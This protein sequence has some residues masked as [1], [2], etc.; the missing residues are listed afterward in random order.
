MTPPAASTLYAYVTSRAM[1]STPPM[2]TD[3]PKVLPSSVV[4]PE[5]LVLSD[6]VRHA[7]V[8]RGLERGD[9]HRVPERVVHAHRPVEVAA[10]VARREDLVAVRV[11]D[12]RV[13]DLRRRAPAQ[14]LE[15]AGVRERLQRRSG[16]V[17]AR[18]RCRSARRC[19]RGSSR[20]SRRTSAPPTCADRSRRARRCARSTESSNSLIQCSSASCALCSRFR[21]S[22]VVTRRPPR[23]SASSP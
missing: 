15:G 22:V 12:R 7:D 23:C 9:V 4:M 3:G 6:D 2:V 8:Q 16:R 18:R 21:S 19:P 20:A 5:L 13:E 11:A 17:R 1:T 10:R 14:L